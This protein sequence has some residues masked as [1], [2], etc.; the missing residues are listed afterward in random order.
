M[1]LLIPKSSLKWYRKQ[2]TDLKNKFTSEIIKA[3]KNADYLYL[4]TDPDREGEA[5]L[6]CSEGS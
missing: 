1:V 3:V 2:Q 4:A 6:A 5:I